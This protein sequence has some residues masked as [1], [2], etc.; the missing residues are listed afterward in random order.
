MWKNKFQ[1]KKLKD[2][3]QGGIKKPRDNEGFLE[4]LEMHQVIYGAIIDVGKYQLVALEKEIYRSP[5]ELR[6]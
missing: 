2:I 3:L 5:I 4:D 6:I 1:I